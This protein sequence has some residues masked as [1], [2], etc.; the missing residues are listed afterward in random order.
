MLTSLADGWRRER[1]LVHSAISISGNSKYQAAMHSEAINCIQHLIRSPAK[2]S[3]HFQTYSYGVI[4]RSFYGIHIDSPTHPFV[5][6]N[7]EFF[8][9]FMP[10]FDPSQ[11]PV[12]IFTHLRYL[13]TWLVPSMRRLQELKTFVADRVEN[14]QENIERQRGDS[15]PTEQP[16][17][18]NEFLAHRKDYEIPDIEANYAFFSLIGAGTRSTHNA[19]LTFVYL[20]MAYPEWQT[21]LQ[22]QVDEVVGPDR[23]P[24]WEDIPNL[25]LVRAVVCEGIRYRTIVAELGIP[26]Q[27]DEDDE[28]QGYRF[29]TGTVFHANY[30]YA[31]FCFH[32]KNDRLTLSSAILSDPVKFPDQHPF[33]PARWVDPSYPTYKEPLTTYPNCQS[34]APFGYGRRACPGYDFAERSLVIAVA[35]MAWACDIRRPLGDEGKEYLPEITYESSPNPRPC[36]FGCR[37]VGREGKVEKLEGLMNQ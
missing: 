15:P 35:C 23:L 19:L 3:D 34:Y 37:I 21:K 33:N 14:F 11:F 2:F 6:E 25:P 29:K 22:A 1:K 17:I 16:G 8:D 24:N 12:N 27:L 5:A 18:F 28:Y 4:A 7:E 9:K 32:A 31:T 20:M 13:P 26:H 10:A 36:E 30:G